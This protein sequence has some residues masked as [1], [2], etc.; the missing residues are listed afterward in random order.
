IR[1]LVMLHSTQEMRQQI[2]QQKIIGAVLIDESFSRDVAAHRPASVFLALDGR[3]SNAAQIVD[4]YISTIATNVGAVLRPEAIP[5]GQTVVRNMFN[6]N[7]DFI[8]FILPTLVVTVAG[9]SALSVTVQSVA[10]ERELGSFDQLMVSPLRLYEILIGKMTPP[11]LIGL[12]N[13]ALYLIIITQIFG[14]PLKGSILMYFVSLVFFL[15]AQIGIGMMVSSIAQTQQQAFLGMFLV[16][17]PIN[18]LSGFASPV[19]NMPVWLQYV[20]QANPQ[21][22][23]IVIME[24]LFLKAMPAMDVLANCVPLF[25]ISLVTLTTATLMFRSRVE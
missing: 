10:R 19:D 5:G 11:M 12:F 15:N 1:N 17:V 25:L 9:I 20:S 4:E 7:L 2:N 8:F 21:M 3:R 14:E 23:M 6:P 13:A 22:H 24:G 16:T 18:M